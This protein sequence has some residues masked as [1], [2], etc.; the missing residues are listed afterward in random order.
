MEL[1][2]PID[3][4]A[5]L[6]ANENINVIRTNTSTAS[7]DIKERT[8]RLPTWKM[9]TDEIDQMLVAHE[10]GHALYTTDEYTEA[11]YGDLDFSGAK[12]YLNILED[13]RVEKLI[14]RTYPGTR[15]TFTVGYKQLNDMDFFGI[16]KRDIQDLSLIDR[17]NMYFKVGYSSG[18][19]F[20][21]EEKPFVVRAEQTETIG[22]VI[23]LAKDIW[24]FCQNKK[25]E[26][27]NH[28]DDDDTLDGPDDGDSSIDDD[29][30]NDE[31]NSSGDN[32]PAEDTDGDQ[33]D[34]QWDDDFDQDGEE[35]DD[36]EDD[37]NEIGD[38]Q[39][40]QKDNPTD[41]DNTDTGDGITDRTFARQIA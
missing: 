1:N 30:F 14:K 18:V 31:P 36:S 3:L 41:S 29:D 25:Q 13:A 24:T 2:Q 37:D 10:V 32:V 38:E 22:D 34:D 35:V 23:Q 17:I 16:A 39:G 19:S 33:D 6:L 8:L 4:I 40:E 28:H 27:E 15:K 26:R 11:L 12:S 5:K 21:S 20:S 9:I 7:F